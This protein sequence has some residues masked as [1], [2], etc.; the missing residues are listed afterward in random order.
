MAAP[1]HK[2]ERKKNIIFGLLL[3]KALSREG[4]AG[5]AKKGGKPGFS[6]FCRVGRETF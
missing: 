5:R 6:A 4:P 1:S 3:R 2:K